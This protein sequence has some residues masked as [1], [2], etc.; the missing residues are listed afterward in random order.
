MFS[1]QDLASF[2]KNAHHEIGWSAAWG[3]AVE[4]LTPAQAAWKP[5]PERHSIWQIVNHIS[6]WREE[7][8]RRAAG[9]PKAGEDVVEQENWRGP[10]ETTERAWNSAKERFRAS[11][12]AIAKSA[13]DDRAPL[14]G[15]L[16]MMGHDFYHVGQIMFL[17]A[18]QGLPPVE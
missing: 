2:Y 10:D 16:N 1:R 3:Q 6:F 8:L 17:R 9:Q 7:V 18:M 5:S 11:H 12:E 13:Q 14:E 4:G 15:V